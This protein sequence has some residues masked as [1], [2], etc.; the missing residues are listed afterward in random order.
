MNWTIFCDIDGTLIKFH[1]DFSEVVHGHTHTECIGEANKKLAQWHCEG[2]TIILTTGRPESMRKVTE[3]M[4]R[5]L[6]II[7]DKLIMGCGS[8]PRLLINDHTENRKAH[9]I[10]VKRDE[11]IDHVILSDDQVWEVDTGAL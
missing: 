10:S 6:G 2:H 4:L 11:G 3:G 7:Y 5:D 1:E 9:A 8:G